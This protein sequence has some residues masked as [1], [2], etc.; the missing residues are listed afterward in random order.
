MDVELLRP[1]TIPISPET[2]LWF[3]F[4]LNKDLLLK[5]LKKPSP[6]PT[7]N[8]L[9]IK[10]TTAVYESFKNE[11]KRELE[12]SETQHLEVEPVLRH[13]LKN[14]ALKILS[15]KVASYIKWNFATLRQLPFKIQISLLQDLLY[16]TNNE[17][18]IEIP[19]VPVYSS[20]TSP[21]H[22][23][24]L[25]LYHRWLIGASLRRV[26]GP[27]QSRTNGDILMDENMYNIIC[28]M[29]NTEESLQFLL[30]SLTWSNIP[31]MITYNCFESLTE[32][33]TNTQLNWEQVVPISKEEFEAQV[34]FDVAVFYF[35]KEQYDLA[36]KHFK[37]SIDSLKSIKN[38]AGFCTLDKDALDNYILAC[39]GKS[40]SLMQQLNTS[41]V[42]QYIGI[43]NILITD[44]QY[45]EIPIMHRIN[46]ELDIQGALSSRKFT[47]ARDLLPKIKA[48]NAVRCVLDKYTF[49]QY[50]FQSPKSQ[51]LLIWAT[52][53]V[54]KN[55]NEVD[56]RLITEYYLQIVHEIKSK[57][58]ISKILSHNIISDMLD[59]YDTDLL[60]KQISDDVEIPDILTNYSWDIPTPKIQSP[61]LEIKLIE[62]E[63]IGCYDQQEIRELLYKLTVRNPG[64]RIWKVN[65]KW[66]I[67]IPLQSV[68]TSIQRGFLQDF[69]FVILAKSRELMNSKNWTSSIGLLKTLHSEV[70]ANSGNAMAKLYILI[71]WEIL[72]VQITQF[73]EEWPA[74]H[75]D[76]IALATACEFCLQNSE[77][78]LP[79]TE[80]ME[81]C[82]LCLLNLRHWDFLVKID[83]RLSYFEIASAIALAC[84]DIIKYKGGKT[85]NK[86]LWELVHPLFCSSPHSN[87]NKR[88][89]SGN[90][91]IVHRDSP[92]NNIR[93]ALFTFLPKLRDSMALNVIVSLLARLYNVLRDES[94]LEL[95]VDY[96]II[97]PAVVT[98]ANS[99][100]SCGVL[101]SLTNDVLQSL[102]YYPSNVSWLRLMGDISYVNGNFEMCLNYYLK[103]LITVTEYFSTPV[104]LDNHIFR[105]MIK[106][107][108]ALGMYTQAAVLCQFLDEPDYQTAFRALQEQKPCNDAIDAYYHCIWDVNILEFLVNQHTRKNEY[109][110][111]KRAIHTLGL[112]E[113]NSNNSEEIQREASNQRKNIFLR[114]LCKQYVR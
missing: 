11:V 31:P 4:L 24:S 67:P 25:V 93:S 53:S 44:N 18:W 114:A 49:Q 56:K 20:E 106:C 89:G 86:D 47:V 77:S 14:I 91:N 64:K 12:P 17:T 104:R 75:V 42:N 71:S 57:D 78:V 27:P 23:F 32:T 45:R 30:E 112:L 88:S 79:R 46:L 100:N 70:Q 95:K 34:N 69:S 97:W 6:D 81:Q 102:Q 90:S 94:S 107:V 8:E 68:V 76:R 73:L 59:D 51:D 54:W 98:N 110:R 5:H 16:F 29:E 92:L 48:L 108:S 40:P 60:E 61:K 52:S 7:P 1:G 21:P 28:T 15:V 39:N 2:T 109:Q 43:L 41:V 85:V 65:P 83:K 99:Y 96:I 105:R 19:H 33:S 66:E 84:Q 58:F 103:S 10:F 36:L 9:I 38:P 13:S 80:I 111:R 63:L 35:F 50:N 101:E 82:A 113:L 55:A 74:P 62:Q 3:E 22:L 87:Q 26:L 72:L 37:T